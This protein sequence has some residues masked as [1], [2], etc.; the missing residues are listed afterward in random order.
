MTHY[1]A[2]IRGIGPGDPKKSNESLRSVLESLG[3]KNVR[4]VISSGNVIFES[5]ET[6]VAKLESLIESS[7][8]T[9]LGFTATT[10][11]RSQDQLQSIIGS[12][13]FDGVLHANTTYQLVTFL[14]KK[15]AK[16]AFDLPYQPPGKPYK[17]VGCTDD[18]VYTITDNTAIKTT[19]LMTWLERQFGKELTSRTPLTIE[20]ILKKMGS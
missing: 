17:V 13:P 8:P 4:S 14:K 15:P 11:V 6:D 7:W 9:K 5:D 1:V 3:L 19:E 12:D 20:R 16:L 10:I 2:L 18:N